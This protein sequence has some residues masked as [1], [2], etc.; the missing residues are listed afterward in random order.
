MAR[1]HLV[2]HRNVIFLWRMTFDAPQKSVA[3]EILMRHRI[4]FTYKGFPSSDIY[5]LEHVQMHVNLDKSAVFIPKR[6][7]YIQ[8]AAEDKH[9]YLPLYCHVSVYISTM[10]NSSISLASYF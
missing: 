5:T 4:A 3:H 7:A 8:L 10:Q 1:E 9:N 2:R 6:R